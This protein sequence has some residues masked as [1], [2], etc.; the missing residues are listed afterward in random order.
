MKK[1][2]VYNILVLIVVSLF[3]TACVTTQTPKISHVHIGHAMTAWKGTPGEKGLFHTA[4]Q[5][6]VLIL[7]YA[8]QEP[9]NLDEIKEMIESIQHTLDPD[10]VKREH[11]NYGFIKAITSARDHILYA[12][13]SQDASENIKSAS[14]SIVQN[15]GEIIKRSNLMIALNNDILK[16]RNFE[17]AKLFVEEIKT[18]A[19]QNLKGVDLDNSGVI[20]N[21]PEEYGIKQL[22][23][24]INAMINKEVPAY[25]T[26]DKKYLF[27]LI[28]L[29]SGVWEFFFGEEG[30]E[31]GGFDYY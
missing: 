21:S 17:D 14:K 9:K 25:K 31:S 24:Q 19:K 28:R 20:G 13:D 11:P 22:K 29:P 30:E 26:V 2:Y 23:H 5:E 6:A 3:L 27:S 15:I 8:S 16:S 18:L 10:L 4:E 7:Q 12:A 1:I